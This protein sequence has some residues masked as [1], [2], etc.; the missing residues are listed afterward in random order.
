MVLTKNGFRELYPLLRYRTMT[1]FAG[2]STNPLVGL[3][4]LP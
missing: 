1:R 2:L 4:Y 3:E